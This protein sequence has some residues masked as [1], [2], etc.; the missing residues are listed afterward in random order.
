MLERMGHSVMAVEDGRAAVEAVR[1]GAF[2]VVLMDVMMPEMDGLAATRA[3]RALTGAQGRIAVI[4]LTANAM[5]TDQERCLEAGMT[6]FETKPISAARLGAA[7]EQAV[8]A[9]VPPGPAPTA[10][11]P[12]PAPVPAGASSWAAAGFDAGR[13]E[14]LRGEIGEGAL[15]AVLRQFSTDSLRQL[16]DMRD[17]ARA[18]RSDLLG[19]QARLVARAARTVGLVQLGLAAAAVQEDVA[20][21]RHDG[22]AARVEALEPLLLAGLDALRR[23][24]MAGGQAGGG[25]AGGGQAGGGQAGA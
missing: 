20:A 15:G 19:H 6:M 18:G 25:Q 21:G 10:D 23:W 8:A 3:I 11:A 14:G 16:E 9:A 22:L 1:R 24:Q 7:I 12:G 2:D 17:L 5:A 4:G 13:L